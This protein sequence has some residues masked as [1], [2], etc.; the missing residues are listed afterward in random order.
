MPKL[1]PPH[2]GLIAFRQSSMQRCLH[3]QFRKWHRCRLQALARRVKQEILHPK[4]SLFNKFVVVCLFLS[5]EDG[6]SESSRHKNLKSDLEKYGTEAI[7]LYA[8]CNRSCRT[9]CFS[10][11]SLIL[12]FHTCSSS[13]RHPIQLLESEVTRKM[14][15]ER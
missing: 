11:F 9:L 5:G 15:R 4:Y 14:D 6:L 1:W 10:D 8:T 12:S 13:Q 2:I 3:E 7:L